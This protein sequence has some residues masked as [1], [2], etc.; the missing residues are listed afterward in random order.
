M[1]LLAGL[2]SKDFKLN[3]KERL[4]VLHSLFDVI[5]AYA[6]DYRLT[7]GIS[8]SESAWNIAKLSATL[9]WFQVRAA[10]NC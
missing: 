4:E 1:L 9:S 5:L 7:R 10:S 8:N 6:Y 2:S 3:T